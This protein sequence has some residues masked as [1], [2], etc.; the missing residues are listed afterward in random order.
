MLLA[1]G[2]DVDVADS[3]KKTALHKA[4]LIGSAAT[5]KHLIEFGADVDVGDQYGYR[6]IHFAVHY[7]TGGALIS[8]LLANGALI[9]DARNIFRRTPL[10]RAVPF[11]SAR[12]CRFL[13]DHGANVNIPDREGD[14]PLFEAA[15]RNAHDCLELLLAWD[16]DHLHIK[17]EKQTLLHVAATRGNKRTFDILANANLKGIDANAKDTMSMTVRSIFATRS[18]VS[19]ETNTAFQSLMASLAQNTEDTSKEMGRGSDSD[20]E[21]ADFVDA[22]ESID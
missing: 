6:P 16:A 13:L 1:A 14:T 9:D 8:L 7:N 21:E 10:I 15:A 3:K 11:D 18:G 22:L 2:A 5:V 12:S 20:E 4:C 17:T 19:D